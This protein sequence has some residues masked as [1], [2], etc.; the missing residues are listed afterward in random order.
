M[1]S[2]VE[3]FAGIIIGALLSRLA[4]EPKLRQSGT[5]GGGPVPTGGRRVS[6][7][8]IAITNHPRF[9]F[10]RTARRDAHVENI[11]LYDRDRREFLQA[12]FRFADGHGGNLQPP[13]SI[14]AG[15]N[16]YLHVF[17]HVEG[18]STYGT[19]ESGIFEQDPMKP[20]GVFGERER[21]FA[22]ILRTREGAEHF[23]PVTVRFEK[24]LRLVVTPA[25][26]DR[27]RERIRRLRWRIAP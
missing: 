3:I 7:L 9:F 11:F 26:R 24:T 4:T 27:W 13:V 22:L 2:V 16:R 18:E 6:I 5:G 25:F 20:L 15:E 10:F 19:F 8:T 1:S 14:A 17:Y 12:R 21:R 23:I